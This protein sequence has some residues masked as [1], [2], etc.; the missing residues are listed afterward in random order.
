MSSEFQINPPH[1]SDI[2]V[3]PPSDTYTFF[4]TSQTSMILVNVSI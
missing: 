1:Q 3:R 4:L 2:N